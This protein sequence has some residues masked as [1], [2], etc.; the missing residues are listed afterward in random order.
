ML[1][2]NKHKRG[3]FMEPNL[4]NVSNEIVN[5]STTAPVAV[6]PKPP[7]SK[8]L[9]ASTIIFALLAVAGIAGAAYFYMDSSNKTADNTKL[10][11]E[12]D[13]IKNETG[14]ELVENDGTTTVDLTK[15]D[16]SEVKSIVKQIYESVSTNISD[17]RFFTTFGDGSDIKIPGTNTYTKS[18][19]SYGIESPTVFYDSSAGD[20]IMATAHT[21]AEAILANNGFTEDR[22]FMSNKLFY[23]PDTRIYCDVSENSLPFTVN[24]SKD[25][26]ISDGD[27]NLSLDLAKIS[28][29]FYVSAH[30]DNI[31]DST[32]TPY[33]RLTAGG[34]G[35]ALLFYRTSP[36]AEWQ[37]FIGTQ[38]VLLCSDY[39]GDVAKAFA[40][41]ICLDESTD[42]IST[43]QP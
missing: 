32:I 19:S 29:E 11:A 12:L 25:T 2:L 22:E 39:T 1:Q 7:K 35:A 28:D 33:Q 8:G 31:I 3:F 15:S 36:D 14:A 6:S 42:E 23:N 30:L 5:A 40:G 10:Q 26:W 9:I 34:P 13:L 4:E 38:G 27:K 18:N 21:Y 20:T 43:V 24:C 16:D 17:G 37:F 41:E